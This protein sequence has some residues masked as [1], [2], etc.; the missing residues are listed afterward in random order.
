L[1]FNGNIPNTSQSDHEIMLL[2]IGTND[3]LGFYTY[4][5]NNGKMYCRVN[6]T[7]YNAETNP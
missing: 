6:G 7:N 4:Y 2:D 1:E 3:Y 5:G